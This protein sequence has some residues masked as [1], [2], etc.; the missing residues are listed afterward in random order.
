M[1]ATVFGAGARRHAPRQLGALL[2]AA[3]AGTPRAAPAAP[4]EPAPATAAEP[5]EP[6]T[7]PSAPGSAPEPRAQSPWPELAAVFPGFLL[8]GSGTWLQGRTLTTE[9]LL[10]LEAASLL[11]IGV[12]GLFIYETG[13]ARSWAGP[14]TLT[15][16]TG[17]GALS[18]SFLANLYAAWAPPQGRG[19]P[20]RR[21]PLLVSALGYLHVSDPHLDDRH[22]LTTE[23]DG[24]LGPWHLLLDAAQSPSPGNQQLTLSSGYRVLGPRAAATS[25]PDGSYL[26]PQLGFSS[27]R[28]DGLGFVSRV[29]QLDLEGRLDAPRLLGDVHGGFFQAAAGLARRWLVFDVPGAQATD[30][31]SL[32]ILH[33]GFGLY[34]GRRGAAASGAQQAALPGG[35]LELYYDHRRDGFAGGLKL[36]GPASGTAGHLG[37]R[38][39]YFLSES[40]GVRVL[41]EGGSSWVLG[42]S[43]L[44]RW[45][46]R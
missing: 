3:L 25:A 2:T 10:L 33:M 38:A 36:P 24:R 27:H 39:E 28:F 12:G 26:E 41:A 30:A 43:G 19:E 7:A 44:L 35:E 37:A 15:V 18:S 29:L 14:A 22:F 31:S 32:L 1:E 9:R 4:V 42:G 21:L 17:T 20:A 16:A 5:V 11:A 45:G 40:L 13:Y 46:L 23:L 8:H 34:L 6:A